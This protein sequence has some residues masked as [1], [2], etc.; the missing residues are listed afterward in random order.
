MRGGM[1]VCFPR[2]R[3]CFTY[4]FG[5]KRLKIFHFH[6]IFVDVGNYVKYRKMVR[7]TWFRRGN[8]YLRGRLVETRP[9]DGEKHAG[10]SAG[11]FCS[12]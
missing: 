9:D 12:V 1:L 5:R 6:Y 4:V 3:T 8:R 2:L 10:R 11:V 7:K